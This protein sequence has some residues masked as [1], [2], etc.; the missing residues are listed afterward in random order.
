MIETK[1]FEVRDRATNI[2]VAATRFDP[3]TVRESSILR[4]VGVDAAAILYTN[5]SSTRS[6]IDPYELRDRTNTTTHT[7]IERNWDDLV[8]GQLIDVRVILGEALEEC[9]SEYE[10]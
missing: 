3:D 2:S 8:S 1:V 5:L 4:H 7:F 10:D 6:A 9:E